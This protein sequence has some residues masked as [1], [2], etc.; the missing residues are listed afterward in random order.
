MHCTEGVRPKGNDCSTHIPGLY[1]AGDA[2]GNML[3]GGVYGALGAALANAAVT[4]AIAGETAANFAVNIRG[5]KIDEANLD[6]LKSH[7]RAPLERK[8]GFSPRWATRILQNTMFPYYVMYIKKGDRMKAA[9]SQVEFLRDHISPKLLARDT[10]ELRLSLET[11][12]MILNA[13]M[14]LRASLAREESRG[15][16]YREDFPRRDDPEGLHWVLLK[17]ED[18]I[19]KPFKEPIPTEYW[20]DMRKSYEERYKQ[21]YPGEKLA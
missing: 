8:G 18:G 17:E 12:N 2:L 11:K 15:S 9:L 5:V 7:I 4:G 20:P 14:R 1:A 16:H 10:H 6:G 19:M 21:R 13:E 3:M